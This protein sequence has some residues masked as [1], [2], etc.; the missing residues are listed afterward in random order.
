VVD[1]HDEVGADERHDLAGGDDVGGRGELFVLDVDGGAHGDEE[2][3]VGR[4]PSAAC[5]SPPSCGPPGVGK[6]TIARHLAD[7]SDMAFEPVSATF[8]G[9]TEPLQAASG[10][11]IDLPNG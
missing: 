2:G 4:S 3:V 11:W 6:T 7:G 5:S 10:K 9:V 8:S 1:D